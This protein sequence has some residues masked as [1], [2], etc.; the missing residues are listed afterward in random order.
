M[1]YLPRSKNKIC[2]R[3][4]FNAVKLRLQLR[5]KSE[6]LFVITLIS[7]TASISYFDYVVN[8]AFMLHPVA[9]LGGGGRPSSGIR[10]LPIERVSS[11]YFLRSPF[12]AD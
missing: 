8:Y 10:P 3:N 12:L 11:L 1:V 6:S 5:R 2:Q 4:K 9:D 7:T